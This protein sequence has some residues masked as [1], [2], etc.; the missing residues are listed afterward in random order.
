MTAPVLVDAAEVVTPLIFLEN[1]EQIACTVLNVS[2]LARSVTVSLRN[3]VGSELLGG[4]PVI[5][6]PGEG[7]GFAPILPGTNLV[8]CQFTVN[9]AKGS[10]RAGALLKPGN[11]FHPAE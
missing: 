4:T 7:T 10:I 2:S 1:P 8:Y 6:D 5:L 11:T 3:H 9:G